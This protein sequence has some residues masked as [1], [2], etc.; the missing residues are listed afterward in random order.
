MRIGVVT[1]SY[2]RGDGDHAGTFVAQHVAQLRARGHGVD[3]IAAGIARSGDVERIHSRLFE[4]A[5]APDILDRGR[6]RD[7]IEAVAFTAKLTAR[8]ARRARRWDLIVAHWLAPSAIAA[9]PARAPLLAIAHG[10]DVHALRR[11]RLLA[12]ALALLRARRAR[13]VFASAE[14]LAIAR[15]HAGRWLDDAA[16]VQPMGVDV[17][18]FAA[19]GRAPTSPPTIAVIARLVPVKGVDVALAA[20]AHV[21]AP[22]RL[23]VAGDGP[24]R[25]TL[26]RAAA[27]NARFLGTVDAARR[28][29]LLREASVVVVPSRELANRRSEGTPTVALEALAA[30]VPVV[31]SAVGGLRALGRAALVPPDDPRALAAAIDRALAA[32]PPPDQLRAAAAAFDWRLV[33]VRLFAHALRAA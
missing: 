22:A 9:L 17:A 4:G 20:L 12:P 26:E 30:G 8:V 11:A 21:R 19:L 14:L 13:L 18:R 24:E 5:G 27:S 7:L 33:D 29:A 16:I 10:G 2:P 1:T 32:P 6:A 15:A 31:A 28:D 3:V 23:V 25:A